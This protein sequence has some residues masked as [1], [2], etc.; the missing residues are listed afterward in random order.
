MG[1][2]GDIASTTSDPA[3]RTRLID[4]GQRMIDGCAG[5]LQDFDMARLQRCMSRQKSAQP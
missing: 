1:A 3:I 5:R 2:L 4:R